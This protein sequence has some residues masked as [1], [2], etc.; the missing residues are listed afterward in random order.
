[1]ELAGQTV[2]VPAPEDLLLQVIVHGLTGVGAASSRWV[3]DATLLLRKCPM[4]WDRFVEQA[5]RHRVLLPA[6]SA[7]RYV[8][9]EFAAPIPIDA[10]WTIWAQPVSSGDRQRFDVMTAPSAAVGFA[11]NRALI[12]SRWARLRTA[13]G[14]VGAAV[15]AP[16]FVA[17]VLHVKYT[18]QVPGE[19]AR[20]LRVRGNEWIT[21]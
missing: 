3:A 19:V 10:L 8:M 7:L 5:T 12:A 17:D 2:M 9:D 15:T 20:R 18:W 4:D 11:G 6:R 21:R 1:M 13:V 14:G 16:R